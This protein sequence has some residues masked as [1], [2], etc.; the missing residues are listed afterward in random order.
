MNY[1]TVNGGP[2]VICYSYMA[3]SHAHNGTCALVL[4]YI[5]PLKQEEGDD[6]DR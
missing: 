2:Y 4:A 6:F 5:E 3:C 1:M